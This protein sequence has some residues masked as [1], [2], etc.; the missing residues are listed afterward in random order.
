MTEKRRLLVR[1]YNLQLRILSLNPHADA[2]IIRQLLAER[3]ELLNRLKE[4][5]TPPVDE[6]D[7][8][9]VN[10]TLRRRHVHK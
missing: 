5:N 1:I 3:I 10:G 7:V 2:L 6:E 9:K 8:D 4:I